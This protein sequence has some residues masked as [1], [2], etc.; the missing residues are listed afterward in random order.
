MTGA[1]AL[2]GLLFRHL[3]YRVQVLGDL[4][5]Q[6]AVLRVPR[7]HRVQE[8]G[9]AEKLE[10]VVYP[11]ESFVGEVTLHQTAEHRLHVQQALR[12]E[13][14]VVAEVDLVEADDGHAGHLEFALELGS[15]HHL[16]VIELLV[17]VEDA[18]LDDDLDEVL[19]DLL[20]LLL[21]SRL[22]ANERKSYHDGQGRTHGGTRG[23]GSPLGT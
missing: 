7:E 19:D 6:L 2:A 15:Q 1:C 18:D 20:R 23:P 22:P 8:G 16:I 14:A 11:R 13:A 12:D 21:V 5:E 10:H 4:A 17:A 9:L 3:Q